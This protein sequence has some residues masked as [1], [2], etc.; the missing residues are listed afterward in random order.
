[1]AA[2]ASLAAAGGVRQQTPIFLGL[3][4]L[5]AL[6]NFFRRAGWAAGLRWTALSA[7][8]GG[9]LCAAWFLPLITSTGGLGRYL[10]VMGAFSARFHATTSL[11][12]G[13]GSFGL[14]RNLRKLGM[15]TL[16]GWGIALL[17]FGLWILIRL[18]K[19]DL[20]PDW[21]KILF[22]LAWLIPALFFYT[23]IHMGQQGLVFVFLPALLLLSALALSRLLPTVEGPS[24]LRKSRKTSEVWP[25]Q[26]TLALS[27]GLIGLVLLHSLIFLAAPEYPLGNERLR[28]LTRATLANSDR[29]Y[30]ERF[31]AIKANFVPESTAILAA[32]WHHV[33]YYLPEYAR[34]PFGLSAKWEKGEGTPRNDFQDAVVTPTDLELQPNNQGQVAIVVFDPYLMAFSESPTSACKLPLRNGEEIEYYV[35]TE[36]Q[37]FHY[38]KHSFG[39]K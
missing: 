7:A 18:V 29:Y 25:R 13:A 39:T 1:M 12:M 9:L 21:S 32:N 16:Y 8:I 38:G 33:E 15:Y 2:A 3:L 17:P 35:L 34:L 14:L 22:L 37:A 6:V 24:R 26:R 10:K 30:Q 19:R 20:R 23:I 27:L 4:L 5:L 11:F 31:E 28:L 36:E